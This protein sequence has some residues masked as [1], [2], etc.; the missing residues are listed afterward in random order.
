MNL[1]QLDLNLLKTLSVLLQEKNTNRTAER[2]NTSQPAV[3]R[4]LAKLRD[5]LGDPLFVRQSRGLK[6]T[7]KGEELA[8]RLPKVLED[9]SEALSGEQFS[10]EKL[11]GV[12]KIALNGFLIETH[13]HRLYE[14]ITQSAP[15]VT[16]ELLNYSTK[17]TAELM[18]G[19][20]DFALS[21]YPLDAPK[22]LRQVA[23]GLLDYVGIVRKSHVLAQRTVL[24]HEVIEYDIG[25]LII[26]EF[27]N[28]RMLLEDFVET[29]DYFR[30]KLRSHVINP[31]LRA[32]SSSDMVFVAP[33]SLMQVIDNDR[34]SYVEVHDVE[35]RNQTKV[36]LVYN[37]KYL[38][39]AKFRWVESI[40]D[41]IIPPDMLKD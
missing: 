32:V 11:V 18:N 29:Q 23:V 33:K 40:C 24:V 4:N 38:R 3:S 20:V 35:K 10:P 25:G 17:T 16:V 14:A 31:L 8:D 15:N 26:P 34:Y 21:Y 41:A 9:L 6:L 2:L 27:N 39:S 36:G 1:Q 12:I 30:P 7:P 28:R 19:E 22:E 5:Q 37:S 13:G